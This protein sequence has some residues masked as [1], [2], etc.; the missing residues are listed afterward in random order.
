MKDGEQWTI[1]IDQFGGYCPA[2]FDNAYP[3]YGNKNQASDMTTVNL[4]DPNVLTQG[5]GIVALT[6]G[7]Q[8]GEL[9]S[10]LIT[11]ITKHAVSSNV[12]HA[13]GA[14][15]VF[16]ITNTA[17][18]NGNFPKTISAGTANVA[19]DVLHYQGKTLVFW[20]DTG[21]DGDIGLLTNDT[22]WDDNWGCYTNDTE[23]L[24]I[25]GWKLIKDVGVNEKVYSLNPK[26]QEVEIAINTETI[27]KDYDGEMIRFISEG[28]D[29]SVTP[30]HKMFTGFRKRIK[31]KD[32]RNIEYKIVRADSLLD[33]TNFKLKKNAIW[34]GKV[35]R[36]WQ[37]PAYKNEIKKNKGKG[38]NSYYQKERKTIPIKTFLTFLGFYISEG[39]C[40]KNGQAIQI[41]Q[42]K[43]KNFY[44]WNVIKENLNDLGFSYSE[45]KRGDGFTINDKQFC[46]YIKNFVKGKSYEKYI[47][48]EILELDKSL[49]IYLYESMMLGDGDNTGRYYTSSPKLRDDFIELVN[50]L[51]WSPTLREYDKRGQK[52][53]NGI[54][55]HISYIV[56]VN[57]QKNEQT[58]NHHK[59]QK[60]GATVIKEQYSGKIVC[61]ALD[62]NH[63][64]LV[65][66]NGK[67]VWC[68][69]S[70]V[71][72]GAAQLQDAP[73][74]GI[75]GGDDV[76]YLTNGIYLSTVNG[77]TLNA[78][79]LNFNTDGETVSVTWNWNRA[80]VAVNR[81][82]ISG[83]N[84]NLSF[85]AKWNGVSSSW[86]GDPIEVAG[87]IGALYT[88]NGITF[89]WWKDGI[90]TGGY[91]FG[92]INGLRLERI[93]RYEGSLPNQAQVG[94]YEGFIGW[95]SSDKLMM[96]GS[97]DKDTPVRMF[98]YMAGGHATIGTW[99][100]PFGSVIIS[101]NVTTSYQLGKASGYDTGAR[102]KTVAYKM[103]GAGHKSVID[104]IK[105]Q[106]ETLATG[107]K[108]DGTLTYDQGVSTK[109]LAQI[110]YSATDT[111]T[112]RKMLISSPILE[113]FRI[114]LSWKNGS[115]TNP[116][117]IRSLMIEG[118][119]TLE[120]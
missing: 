100:A 84:F 89:V 112:I 21:V 44:T 83:S 1:N 30:D 101:S 88:K 115:V 116:V 85:I 113:D 37:I 67:Q 50:K 109:A 54:A 91:N 92:Y 5:P 70:T 42:S 12:A 93:T 18:S 60:W 86:E 61:L 6:G 28:I 98:E 104:N 69:N 90:S 65:R 73:H 2:Y 114:D 66:R 105:V 46:E 38:G 117:K 19:T 81:P 25:N 94:E 11:G 102:Y 26:T 35:I 7:T 36:N 56:G 4:I 96:W 39:C 23:V 64:M 33:K 20:N 13:C 22:V 72:T 58:F 111:S 106:F 108:L 97:R 10:V 40:R 59:K 32:K 63:I 82:N 41:S 9:G 80:V 77:T 95:I 27:N 107:A 68:G 53:L 29:I 8:A 74:Y 120:S 103:S 45:S 16:K 34:V 55:K 76:A 62:K 15:K 49:L 110:A 119:Y 78:T 17:V 3:F 47:P 51:G 43:E 24:T 87:E 118:H 75:V 57:K 31:G 48:K 79:A 14:N 99:A 52:A 71:A